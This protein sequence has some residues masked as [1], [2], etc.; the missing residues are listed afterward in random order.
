MG[1]GCGR[2]GSEVAL[3]RDASDPAVVVVRAI[4]LGERAV[5]AGAVSKTYDA[6]GKLGLLPEPPG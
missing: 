5:F 3:R 4:E 1:A 6:P 2:D